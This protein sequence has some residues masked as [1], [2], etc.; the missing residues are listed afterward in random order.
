LLHHLRIGIRVVPG[1]AGP[2][3]LIVVVLRVHICT[4]CHSGSMMAYPVSR[5]GNADLPAVSP[6]RHPGRAT[7]C[8]SAWSP[9]R[10]SRPSWSNL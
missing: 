2:V 6:V 10:G 7:T 4:T 3:T 1:V 8:T 5:W 9:T